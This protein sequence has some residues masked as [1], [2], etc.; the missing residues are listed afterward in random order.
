MVTAAQNI[1]YGDAERDPIVEITAQLQAYSDLIGQ[2]R[3]ALA[4]ADPRASVAPEAALAPIRQAHAIVDKD[5]LPAAMALNAA[6]EQVLET[7]WAQRLSRSSGESVALT[8]A[9]VLAL[10]LLIAAQVLVTSRTRRQVNPGLLL[11]TLLF[12]LTLFQVHFEMSSGAEALRVAKEDAFDSVRALWKTRAALYAANS[13]ESYFLLDPSRKPQYADRFFARLKEM[14][15]PD[16]ARQDGRQDGQQDGRAALA[17]RSR[18]FGLAGCLNRN[19]NGV[20]PYPG[21]LGDELN[22]VTFEH[23]CAEASLLFPLLADYVAIDARIRDLDASGDHAGALKLDVGEEPGESDLP[24]PR[25]TPKSGCSSTST[26][27]SSRAGPGR[28]T[29]RR[30]RSAFSSSRASS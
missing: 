8:A 13:D 22:N 12:A 9:G 7:T 27:W 14:A 25:S 30:R 4:G 23:E 6:N 24:S 11:A 21:L 15:G 5:L 1:T 18:A 28:R 17:A 16:F 3:V 29:R 10:A 26:R 20:K 2:A 19:R